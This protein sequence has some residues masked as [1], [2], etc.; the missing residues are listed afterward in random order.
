[1]SLSTLMTLTSN[2]VGAAE[3][4]LLDAGDYLHPDS[5]G[6]YKVFFNTSSAGYYVGKWYNDG[7]SFNAATRFQSRLAKPLQTLML[8]WR[9]AASSAAG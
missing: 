6:S 5:T 1:M 4:R 9:M 3:T 7:A 8:F 2:L